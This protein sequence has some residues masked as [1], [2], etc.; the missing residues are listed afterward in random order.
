MKRHVNSQQRVGFFHR[1][2][3]RIP[4][5]K[6]HEISFE[7]GRHGGYVMVSDRRQLGIETPLACAYGLNQSK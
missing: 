6:S 1:K 5:Q 3:Q 2:S 7:K 4:V